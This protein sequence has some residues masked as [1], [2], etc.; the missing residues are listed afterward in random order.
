MADAGL[1]PRPLYTSKLADGQSANNGGLI[2]TYAV[3]TSTPKA[4]Q[5]SRTGA[6]N[7][8]PVVLDSAGEAP[9][10]FLAGQYKIIEKTSAG[11]T[12]RTIDEYSAAGDLPTIWTETGSDIYYNGGNVYI[13]ATTGSEKLTV[14]GT[15]SISSTLSVTGATTLTGAVTIPSSLTMGT[16][17]SSTG[18]PGVV[19]N[20]GGG[21]NVDFRVETLSDTNA[22]FVNSGSDTIQFMADSV[23]PGV[24]TIS[25]TTMQVDGILKTT[26]SVEHQ[27][28]ATVSGGDLAVSAGDV[29][30]NGAGKG[31]SMNIGSPTD[32]A[33]NVTLT[34][35]TATITNS[36]ISTSDMIFITRETSS[37]TPG[38]LTYTISNGVSWTITS[39]EVTDAGGLN[40][41]I[42][43]TT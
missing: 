20:D 26:G 24:M 36:N 4:T 39:T 9:I 27:N 28:G 1:G 32:M 10:W 11:V 31:L 13:G 38:I 23:S 40:Y 33:G 7:A 30:I 22:I 43:H 8:N 42:I 16:F 15:A 18:N 2:Y 29:N 5:V 14:V 34:G 6:N 41:F 35:G 17:F 21:A 12:L 3:G 25:T 37:G 19:I